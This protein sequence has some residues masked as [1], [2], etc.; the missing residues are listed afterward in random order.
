[1]ETLRMKKRNIFTGL[2]R[3]PHGRGWIGGVCAGLAAHFGWNTHLVR[4]VAAIAAVLTSFIPFL[5]AYG[6]LWYVLE[7]MDKEERSVPVAMSPPERQ[8]DADLRAR[9]LRL[10]ERLRHLEEHVTDGEFELR[11]EL[12]KL[13]QQTSG[14]G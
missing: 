10:D 12:R 11:R 14:Q 5:I 3:D 6:L 2:Q 8:R 1:M 4:I 7:P 9:F 13:E